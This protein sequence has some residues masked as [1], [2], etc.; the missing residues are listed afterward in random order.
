MANHQR[1][2]VKE[3]FWRQTVKQW[4]SSG[5]SVRSFCIREALSEASFHQW[6]RELALR[7]QA[8][9]RSRSGPR[10]VPIEIVPDNK[11][12]PS[13]HPIEILLASGHIVRLSRA[14]EP[15]ALAAVVDVLESKRC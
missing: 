4:Q 9:R 5:L 6:R 11:P 10:F 7:D 1:D 13:D 15:E 14:F 2:P 12:V 3:Q 8:A